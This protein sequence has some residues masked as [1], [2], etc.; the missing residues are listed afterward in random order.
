MIAE[1]YTCLQ[2]CTC[3][4]CIGVGGDHLPNRNVFVM[5]KD[6]LID[7]PV[8]AGSALLVL[9]EVCTTLRLFECLSR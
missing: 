1:V 5:Q 4:I 7:I 2:V 3:H 6:V 8:L 9:C